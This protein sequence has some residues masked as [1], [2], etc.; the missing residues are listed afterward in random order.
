MTTTTAPKEF[1]PLNKKITLATLKKFVRDNSGQL[2]INVKSSFD[3][4][5]DGLEWLNG[6][7][8]A[9]IETTDHIDHT[10]GIKGAWLVGSSRDYF[11]H[12]ND[13]TY[14]GIEVSNSCGHFIIAIKTSL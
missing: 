12:Y 8:G 2:F 14:S 1:A 11:G 7:F 6:G 10:L 13:N 4:M 9:A 5:T 3:G